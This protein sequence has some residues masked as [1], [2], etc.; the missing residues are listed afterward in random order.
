[1]LTAQDN[2][3]K[4]S[5][6]VADRQVQPTIILAAAYP[7]QPSKSPFL[8][9]ESRNPHNQTLTLVAGFAEGLLFQSLL[10]AMQMDTLN[11]FVSQLNGGFSRT[12]IVSPKP[13]IERCFA[14]K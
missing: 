8:L 4:V 11:S 14:E 2:E 1:M 10:T 12:P 5:S 9:F 3:P 13:D 7:N 6:R